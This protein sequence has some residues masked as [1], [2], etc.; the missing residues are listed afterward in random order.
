MTIRLLRKSFGPE[1]LRGHGA[2]LMSAVTQ[3][4]TLHWL[5]FQDFA[6]VANYSLLH[7][8]GGSITNF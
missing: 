1:V 7:V 2:E 4:V 6:V 5:W 3:V 8:W